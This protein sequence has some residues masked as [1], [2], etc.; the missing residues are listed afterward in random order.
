MS[1]IKVSEISEKEFYKKFPPHKYVV[2]KM[3]IGINGIIHYAEV[4]EKK[5]DVRELSFNKIIK[6]MI[7]NIYKVLSVKK[8]SDNT[9]ML[10]VLIKPPETSQLIKKTYYIK[11]FPKIEFYEV[12]E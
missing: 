1:I 8:F 6:Q 12:V 5:D 7:P 11:K 3:K 10:E 4:I 2:K 9:A